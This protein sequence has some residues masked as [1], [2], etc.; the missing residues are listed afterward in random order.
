MARALED[1]GGPDQV[2][3]EL[4]AT[5]GH[6]LLPVV[7]DKA[8][9]WK[10]RTMKAK[11]LWTTWATL[12]V[13][14]VVVVQVL[15]FTFAQVFLVP[16]LDK[17]RRLGWLDTGGVDSAVLAWLEASLRGLQWVANNAIWFGLIPVGLWGL[18][19]WRVRSENKSFMRL[20]AMGTV[21]LGL[22]VGVI[23]IT[24]GLVL[25]F[26]VGIQ[27]PA[28]GSVTLAIE[29]MTNIDTAIRAIEQAREK[30]D[31]KK[32][33]NQASSAS[34]AINRLTTVAG[35]IPYLP[36]GERLSEADVRT[37]LAVAQECLHDAQQAAE[38]MDAERLEVAMRKFH[39]AYKQ[40]HK[41][42]P[43]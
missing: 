34:V 19:E 6:R 31:W 33:Q 42:T 22:M 28:T 38:K 18:F 1:Y 40:I 41:D 16:K 2:R 29:Q 27:A 35:V 9:Q 30:K 11:W 15:F 26:M 7:I 43:K 17:I 5:H 8:M 10:E 21:S 25:P 12:V 20:S 32:I 36:K 23:F 13:A 14:G 24:G 39:T 4:E 37:Q 3:S